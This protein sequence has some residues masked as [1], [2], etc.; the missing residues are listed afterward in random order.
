ML[1]VFFPKRMH[2]NTLN[3]NMSYET[4]PKSKKGHN[5]LTGLLKSVLFCFILF[6]VNISSEAQDTTE[7]QN[8]WKF[9]ILTNATITLNSYSDN[10]SGDEFSAFS[11]LWQF[12]GTAEKSLTSIMHNKNTLKLAFGQTSLQDEDELSGEKEW[13]PMKKS[14]DLIDFESVFRFTLKTF[15]DP[16]VS[17]RAVS[18]FADLRS[19]DYNY[20]LNPL[21]LTE[22]FGAIKN[23]IKN[24]NVDWTARLGGAARQSIERNESLPDSLTPAEKVTN[25][26]GLEFVTDF[27]AKSKDNRIN[28]TSQLKVY[29]ALFS[30]ISKQSNESDNIEFWRY[31]DISW[32]NSF[33]VSLIK[34]IALNLYVQLLYDREIDNSVRH[35]QTVGLALTYSFEN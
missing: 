27:K 14:R 21:T 5:R 20:Y 8:K 7:T 30:S 13:Q 2:P 11:W 28:F 35:R 32:E 15:V 23:L 29:G 4:F 6:C 22:S 16:F 31:P 18:Q 1:S 24:K 34:Y 25:D 19:P 9:S 10:W 3:T 17:V 33:D 12:T 26:G